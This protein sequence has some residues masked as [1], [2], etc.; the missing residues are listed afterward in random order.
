MCYPVLNFA[1]QYATDI[2]FKN[3]AMEVGKDI[4]KLAKMK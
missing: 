4:Y 1:N 3:T 2:W